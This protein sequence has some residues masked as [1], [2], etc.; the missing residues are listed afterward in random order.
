MSR[1]VRKSPLSPGRIY[2]KQIN[3]R[4][5]NQTRRRKFSSS[6]NVD[7]NKNCYDAK[8]DLDNIRPIVISVGD[9]QDPTTEKILLDS[10]ML[11]D[12]LCESN[13]NRSIGYSAKALRNKYTDILYL[14]NKVNDIPKR[15]IRDKFAPDEKD[16]DKISET[17]IEDDEVVNNIHAGEIIKNK[18]YYAQWILNYVTSSNRKISEKEL[19]EGN[20]NILVDLSGRF[21]IGKKHNISIRYKDEKTGKMKTRKEKRDNIAT[22]LYSKLVDL[23]DEDTVLI[24]LE[25]RGITF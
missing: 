24:E 13:T 2:S 4:K 17:R 15:I 12:S 3:R 1:R 25:K 9:P 19:L 14:E 8:S 18:K 7:G 5:S 21:I 20:I 23:Y 11:I 6:K 16:L 22:N 10:Q